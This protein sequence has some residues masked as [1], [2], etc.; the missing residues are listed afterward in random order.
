MEKIKIKIYQNKKEVLA[1]T[2]LFIFLIIM[3]ILI[4]LFTN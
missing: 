1:L 3:A 4:I 2:G